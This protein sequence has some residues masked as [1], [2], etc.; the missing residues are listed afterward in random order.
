MMRYVVAILLVMTP[1]LVWPASRL[2]FDGFEDG[3][4]NAWLQDSPQSKCPIVSTA[5][6]GAAGAHSGAFMARCNWASENDPQGNGS[7]TWESLARNGSTSEYSSD[8]LYRFW[9]RRD[10]DLN[11]GDG[12]KL[13]R[14]GNACTYGDLFLDN[15]P[16]NGTFQMATFDK[17]CSSFSRYWGGDNAGDRAWHK[18]EL[19]FSAVTNG[20]VKIWVDDSL[21]HNGTGIALDIPGTT[22]FYSYNV[23]W[24]SIILIS[25]WSASAPCCQHDANNHIYIDDFEIYVDSGSGATGSLADGTITVSG[26]DTTNPTGSITAPTSGQMITVSPF[27]ISVSASDETAMGGVSCTVDGASIGAEDTSQPYE[28][29]WAA[30]GVS[31]GPHSVSC[32]IRD[33]ANN[34]IVVNQSFHVGLSGVDWYFDNTDASVTSSGTWSPSTSFPGYHGS[35]YQYCDPATGPWFQ[36]T[37]TIVAGRYRIYAKWPNGGDRPTE[38]VYEIAHSS[39]T[40]NVNANQNVNGGTWVQLGT[41]TLGSAPTFRVNCSSSGA[42]GTVAD[43]IRLSPAPLYAA[44]TNLQVTVTP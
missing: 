6:D 26:G 16:D 39:G 20:I 24:T 36:W 44:P 9:I 21:V 5:L 41:Y 40:A 29:S 38:A 27:T 18:I 19:Y 31:N 3:T 15:D 33:A 13:F 4:S 30:S 14:V 43:A 34:S 7:G 23:S 32:T 25:N 12:P 28:F 35:N 10:A 11:G 22:G 8:V 1:N 42:D 2:F 17:D 37:P